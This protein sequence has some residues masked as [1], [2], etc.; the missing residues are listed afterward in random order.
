M[1]NNTD[2]NSIF[3]IENLIIFT[4]LVIILYILFKLNNC[5]CKKNYESF[6]LENDMHVKESDIKKDFDTKCSKS[7]TYTQNTTQDDI[8]DIIKNRGGNNVMLH[9][10]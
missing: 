6:N 1:L 3:I 9:Q 4:L 8:M 7:E 5:E 10:V 2:L